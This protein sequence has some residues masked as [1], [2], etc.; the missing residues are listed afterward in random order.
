MFI[1]ILWY[2]IHGTLFPNLNISSNLTWNSIIYKKGSDVSRDEKLYNHF[3][4]DNIVS[5]HFS[6]HKIETS[7]RV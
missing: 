2:I 6:V 5:E 7:L 3:Y 1:F 4:T